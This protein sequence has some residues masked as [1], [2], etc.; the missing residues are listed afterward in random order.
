MV[1][2]PKQAV[3]DQEVSVAGPNQAVVGVKHIVVIE[4]R[5]VSTWRQMLVRNVSR[6]RT[7][8]SREKMIIAVVQI[9]AANCLHDS[10]NTNGAK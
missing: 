2:S 10:K 6:K 1:A 9:K 7:K 4:D 5:L 3:A 8:L